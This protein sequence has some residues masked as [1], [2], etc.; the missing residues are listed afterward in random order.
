M[1]LLEMAPYPINPGP[2]SKA[3]LGCVGIGFAN[4]TPN[5]ISQVDADFM[6]HFRSIHKTTFFIWVVLSRL[7]DFFV[8]KS[9]PL[10]AATRACVPG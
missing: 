4:P 3:S 7:R 2:G 5:H 1:G 10:R 8:C 6:G 9:P